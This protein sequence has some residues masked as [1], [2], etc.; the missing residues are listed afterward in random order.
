ML[1]E[2]QKDSSHSTFVKHVFLV[3][4]W[5]SSGKESTFQ[6][7]G[8]GFDPFSGNEHPMCHCVKKRKKKRFF[9]F[10]SR[11]EGWGKMLAMDSALE[12]V[13]IPHP[14]TAHPA[15]GRLPRTSAPS[16]LLTALGYF[17]ISFL[18]QCALFSHRYSRF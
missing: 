13:S 8:L 9:A 3:L 16:P 6:C 2:S 12:S 4:P 1:P 18:C 17:L 7:R 11:W 15:P 5:W 10:S 14:P